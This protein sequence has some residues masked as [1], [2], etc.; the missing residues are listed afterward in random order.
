[1]L[2]GRGDVETV[3]VCVMEFTGRK[4]STEF[5]GTV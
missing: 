4:Y 3:H 5:T 1:M 2:G